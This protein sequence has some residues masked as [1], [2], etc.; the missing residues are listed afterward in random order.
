MSQNDAGWVPLADAVEGSV[1]EYSDFIEWLMEESIFRCI[2]IE[3]DWQCEPL[4]A[5]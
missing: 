4:L 3:L 5:C 2:W 1:R